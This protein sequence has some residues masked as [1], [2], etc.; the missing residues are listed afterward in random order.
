MP[1]KTKDINEE[2]KK[3]TTA[4]KTTATKKKANAAKRVT[5][6]DAT[7]LCKRFSSLPLIIPYSS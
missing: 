3:K 7:T 1:T 6:I 4:Q 2:N 5:Q